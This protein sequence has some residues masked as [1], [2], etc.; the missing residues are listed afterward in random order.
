MKITAVAA[1][2]EYTG[3]IRR[4][5]EELISRL[6]DAN[7]VDSVSV[8]TLKGFDFVSPSLLRD[9]KVSLFASRSF[10]LPWT[11][12]RTIRLYKNC[13]VFLLFTEP[14]IIFNSL[15]PL[16]LF[17]LLI[18]RGVLPKSKWI[19]IQYDLILYACPKDFGDTATKKYKM[20]KN[21]FS[22]VPARYVAVSESTKH[23]AIK[24]WGLHPDNITV[25]YLS[26]FMVPKT[27]RAH[28][29]S[30]K[31]LM[32]SDISPRKNHVRLIR[33][34]E[35]VHKDTPSAELIIAGYVRINVPEFEATLD[36]ILRRNEGIRITIRG[37]VSDAEMRS[38][39]EEADVFV[40]PSLYEGFGLPVLEAMACGCPVIA[41]NVSSLPEVVGDAGLLIDPYDVEAL[42]HAISTVLADDDL[43]REMSK[44]GIA[45]AQKFSWEKA[46][47]ELLA[48]CREVAERARPP[49][50]S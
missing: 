13:D 37:Y 16:R 11:F 7:S 31:I 38:L 26:S 6:C 4:A 1:F 46:G 30:K 41:S 12:W 24:Y 43:K 42:A 40:Y 2:P 14:W 49:D 50:D 28:F 33:A 25:I 8:I 9:K 18:K 48:V 35:R 22:D 23:D 17:A 32:V 15:L 5:E 10:L 44:K 27:P 47:T 20:W 21:Q 3:G 39:Y 19:Q 36:D 45:Q 29:G 34:F